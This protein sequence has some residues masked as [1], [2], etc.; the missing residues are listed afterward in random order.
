MRPSILIV[1]DN[2]DI[3]LTMARLLSVHGYP[4]DVAHEGTTALTLV[5]QMHYVLAI[6][7]GN[8]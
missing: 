6:I 1:D 8:E 2:P 4:A 7:F 5:D 3:C